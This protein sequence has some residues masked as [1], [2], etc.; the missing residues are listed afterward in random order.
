MGKATR[1]VELESIEDVDARQLADWMNQVASVPGVG[2]R[3]R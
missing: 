3:K 1:G 2:G